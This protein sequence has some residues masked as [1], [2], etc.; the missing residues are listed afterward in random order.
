MKLFRDSGAVLVRCARRLAP[1]FQCDT[2]A[3]AAQMMCHLGALRRF[4]CII[5]LLPCLLVILTYFVPGEL[6]DLRLQ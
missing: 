2:H 3:T 4:V 5:L 1:L 6:Y